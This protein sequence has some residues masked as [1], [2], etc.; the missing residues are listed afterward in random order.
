MSQKT[1]VRKRF[2][3]DTNVIITEP[4]IAAICREVLKG[5]EYVCFLFAHVF[6]A[7]PALSHADLRF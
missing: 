7:E 3:I 1:T 6:S 5:L 2:I 4:L